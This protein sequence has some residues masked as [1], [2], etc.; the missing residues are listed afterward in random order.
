[1]ELVAVDHAKLIVKNHVMVQLTMVP[2]TV[3]LVWP[4]K[5]IQIALNVVSM[6]LL[7]NQHA[8]VISNASDLVE[9]VSWFA[10]MAVLTRPPQ[11]L[12][13]LP[14]LPQLPQL[15]QPLQRRQRLRQLLQ[16]RS[17]KDVG[18]LVTSIVDHQSVLMTLDGS[19]KI[20]MTTVVFLN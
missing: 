19:G 1:M 2:L 3:T 6:L 11:R 8:F 17:V 18:L 10:P 7:M 5:W 9:T 20:P 12:Q 14:Q 13:P 4:A 15:L 16:R